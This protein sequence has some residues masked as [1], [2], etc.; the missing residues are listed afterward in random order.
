MSRTGAGSLCVAS[1]SSAPRTV[2]FS[3]ILAPGPPG[4]SYAEQTLS[5]ALVLEFAE[6]FSGGGRRWAVERSHSFAHRRVDTEMPALWH[7]RR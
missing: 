4:R 5:L 6:R 2:A 1:D 7:R 3:G